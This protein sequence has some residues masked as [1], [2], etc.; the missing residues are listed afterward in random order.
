MKSR[1]SSPFPIDIFTR[2][3]AL[4]V[5][6]SGCILYLQYWLDEAKYPEFHMALKNLNR[7]H[8]EA[9]SFPHFFCFYRA[10]KLGLK[11]DLCL[12]DGGDCCWCFLRHLLSKVFVDLGRFDSGRVRRITSIQLP[13]FF[14]LRFHFQTHF[15]FSFSLLISSTQIPYGPKSESINKT[16]LLEL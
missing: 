2:E 11:L 3:Q 12:Y 5:D 16:I 15:C 9:S 10:R 4:P 7:N 1:K 14:V 6:K 8:D 13:F